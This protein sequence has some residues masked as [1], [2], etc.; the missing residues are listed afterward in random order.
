MPGRSVRK[1]NYG[2][3]QPPEHGEEEQP[4]QPK[5]GRHPVVQ[6]ST[7]TSVVWQEQVVIV[8]TSWHAQLQHGVLQEEHPQGS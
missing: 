8:E 6:V 2:C 7:K 4:N 1:R 3:P 5:N